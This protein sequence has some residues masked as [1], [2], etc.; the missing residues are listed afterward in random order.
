MVIMTL[1][2]RVVLQ[3]KVGSTTFDEEVGRREFQINEPRQAH[4]V[5]GWAR[6][7]FNQHL[8]SATPDVVVRAEVKGTSKD[9]VHYLSEGKLSGWGGEVQCRSGVFDS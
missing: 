8:R 4:A 1:T 6:R 9:G 7:L 3:R 2:A 5:K